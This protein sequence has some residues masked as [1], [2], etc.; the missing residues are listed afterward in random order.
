MSETRGWRMSGVGWRTIA[1]IL[2][3]LVLGAAPGALA[4]EQPRAGGVLTFAVAETPPSFDGHR[5]T[6][7]AMLHPTAP[8]YSTLL[9]FDPDEY[10]KIEGDVAETWTPSKDGLTYTFK[11]R[12]G[13]RFH[14]GSLLTVRDVKATYDRIIFPPEGVASARKASY[15]M[16]EEVVA[17][18]EG[19]VVFRLKWPSASFLASLASPWNFIYK[20][21]LLA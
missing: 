19:T 16:V 21:D 7:F 3:G 12:K 4:A 20:A 13:I 6:T 18:D 15:A 10:P 2:M 14:D 11:I 8:H 17:P 1:V 9:R 5:E